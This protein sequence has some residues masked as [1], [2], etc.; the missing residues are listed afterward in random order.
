MAEE[1]AS[2][3]C[4]VAEELASASNTMAVCGQDPAE[5]IRSG[6]PEKKLDWSLNSIALILEC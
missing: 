5:R 6:T 3:S 1:L 2:A 4:R